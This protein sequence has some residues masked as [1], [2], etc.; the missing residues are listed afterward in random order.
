MYANN[1]LMHDKKLYLLQ[2]KPPPHEFRDP[3]NCMNNNQNLIT[4]FNIVSLNSVS[5][6]NNIVDLPPGARINQLKQCFETN[7]FLND[8][9]H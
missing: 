7:F 9:K 8:S 3:I 4:N 6:N 5:D 2:S 1:K